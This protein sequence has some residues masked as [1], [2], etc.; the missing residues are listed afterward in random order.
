ME[1]V[2]LDHIH[3]ASITLPSE[4]EIDR[5]ARF[6][7][8]LGDP[9]KLKIVCALVGDGKEREICAGS[10]ATALGMTK[11]A[12]SHQLRILREEG[13]IRCRREGKHVIYALDDEHVTEA[14][15]MT[16]EHVRH[17]AVET[18]EE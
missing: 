6:L 8:I 3:P 13:M 12:V 16:V 10:I 4:E 2:I 18:R 14:V 1:E 5:A 9:T 17:K 15:R 7:R 11:S